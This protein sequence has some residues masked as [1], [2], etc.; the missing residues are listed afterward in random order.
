MF[1]KPLEKSPYEYNIKRPDGSV[2]RTNFD[3]V[4]KTIYLM[5]RGFSPIIMVVGNQR[6]GKSFFAVWLGIKIHSFF[7][8]M[9]G[10]DITKHTYYDPME[11]IKHLKDYRN[12]FMILDEAGV[13]MNNKEWMKQLPKI[14][15]KILISQ[16]YL[17]TVQIVIAPFLNNIPKGI[18]QQIDMVCFARKRG[19]ITVKKIP[20]KY[21][22][23]KDSVPTPYTLEQI[24]LSM[25][26]VPSGIWKTYEKYSFEKKEEMRKDLGMEDDYNVNTDIWERPQKDGE[27]LP[28]RKNIGRPRKL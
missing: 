8:G 3:V 25:K 4:G 22:S 21:D 19:V 28:K 7:H 1:L 2:Y 15:E 24:K 5:K 9:D 17:R 23:V 11:T 14:F 20:K 13:V 12:T 27:A 16:G 10:F 26:T 18:R 6:M